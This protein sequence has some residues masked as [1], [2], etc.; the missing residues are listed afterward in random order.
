[1]EKQKMNITFLFGNGLDLGFGLESGYKSFYPYFRQNA[2]DDNIIKREIE[3]DQKDNYQN[4]SDLEVALGKFTLNVSKE[5]IEK[6][7]QDKI[8]LDKLLNK[9][10]LLQEEKFIY[11]DKHIHNP[12]S[13]ICWMCA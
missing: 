2:S 6:F 3:K 13:P 1:M 10:L 9:Y 5:N 4:W 8:E 7:I 11:D 12:F